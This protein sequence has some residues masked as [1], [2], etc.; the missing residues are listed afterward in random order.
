M[1]VGCR[2]LRLVSTLASVEAEGTMPASSR[3][4]SLLGND[5]RRSLSL[6]IRL[7]LLVVVALAAAV[8]AAPL[9]TAPKGVPLLPGRWNGLVPALWATP[10]SFD[11]WRISTSC[12]PMPPLRDMVTANCWSYID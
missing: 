1:P 11:S 9:C 4:D 5:R 2:R 6:A 8:S 7:A 12:R 3:S 10:L